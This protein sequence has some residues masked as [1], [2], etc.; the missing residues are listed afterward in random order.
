[1]KNLLLIFTG[2]GIGSLFRFG[3]GRFI[4]KM[5]VSPFPYGTFIVNIL[6]C[7]LIGFIIFYTERYGDKAEQWRFFLATGLC[8]GF[9]T[10][11]TFS[12]ENVQLLNDQRIL[13]FFAYTIG[14]VAI[15]ILATYGGLLLARNI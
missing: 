10:F 3:L 5:T 7:F 9:T 8:G 1:M 15:G 14:S 4:N 6:G 13:V 11:S 2:G 12:L